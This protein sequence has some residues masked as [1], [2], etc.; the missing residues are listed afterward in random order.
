ML[1][2]SGSLDGREVWGGMD[3]CIYMVES[4]RS[5]LETITALLISYTPIQIKKLEKREERREKR[6]ER[7]R[8]K[9]KLSM[10]DV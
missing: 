2:V 9:E 5:S 7:K 6:K 3:T 4:L 8:K 10:K 1:S